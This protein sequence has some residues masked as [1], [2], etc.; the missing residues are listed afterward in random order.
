M[1]IVFSNIL[2]LGVISLLIV[3]FFY[4][5]FGLCRRILRERDLLKMR[6]EGID[7]VIDSRVKERTRQLES[8]RDSIS[9]Y[10]VQ[11]FELAQELELKNREILEQKDITA[12][13][14]DKLREAYYEIKKLD[15]FR[16]QIVRM[17]IHDLK[18]PLN[19]ILNLT[20][21]DSIP[22]KP[23]SVIRQISFEMLD[24][25]L[26][27]LEVHKFEEMK[28]KLENE[29]VNLNSLVKDTVEKFSAQFVNAS[30]ELK[31]SVPAT[32]WINADRH[33]VGRIFAN[34]LSNAIKYTPS[35]GK[36]EIDASQMDE[37][38][39]IEIR[40]NGKGI[41]EDNIGNLFQMYAQGEKPETL[42]ST[43][44]GIGLAYCKLAVEALGG[45]IGLNSEQGAGTTVWFSIPLTGYEGS[46]EKEGHSDRI[47]LKIP[48]L[49]L[50][51]EDIMYLKPHTRYL[52][53]IDI[54]E[55]TNIL[56]LTA[57]ITCA[58]N[59]RIMRWKESV[60]ETLFSA[61]E[62]RYK[63]LINL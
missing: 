48:D 9:V 3:A 62:K 23:R 1:T 14:S 13:Q 29:N 7:S 61:N 60:E 52:Q 36:V 30:I 53:T 17:M 54:C 56:A 20:D 41:H 11:K 34:L 42:Y 10:A 21:T 12:K 50:T 37:M 26:N 8:I 33:I 15:S 24:L 22:S 51:D 44:T 19:V 46:G 28:M 2:I 47:E 35:G 55:I 5:Y 32:Y 27:I 58:D 57:K 39:Y 59:E 31:T 38:V 45:K 25:I 6:V 49:G 40:D 18:N 43:S 63:E 16:Q 4:L